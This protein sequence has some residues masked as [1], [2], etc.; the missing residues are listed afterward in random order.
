M[1]DRI[2][3]LTVTLE[4]DMR[5]DDAEGIARMIRGFRGVDEVE[6]GEPIDFRD[7]QARAALRRELRGRIEAFLDPKP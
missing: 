2:R 3:T 1:T 6:L 5:E 4:M 7:H